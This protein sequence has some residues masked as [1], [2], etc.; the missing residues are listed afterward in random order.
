MLR[1]L[2]CGSC[3]YERKRAGDKRSRIDFSGSE[4][5]DGLP[6]WSAA[7]PNNGDFFHD[8]RPRFHR[9]RAVKCRF[10]NQSAP[11]FSDVVSETKSRGRASGINHQPIPRFDPLQVNGIAADAFRLDSSVPGK[12]QLLLVFAV[13]HYIAQLSAQ[14]A[15]DQLSE[16]SIS[17][18]RRIRV[19]LDAD[20][21]ENFAGGRQ[22]FNEYSLLIADPIGNNV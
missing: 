9:R 14:N 4:K 13:H 5:G 2:N 11:R 17:Q 20:L 10:Q 16:L 15:C 1:E 12:R 3:F 7:R 18:D 22:R 19:F 21:F 8:D 6:K